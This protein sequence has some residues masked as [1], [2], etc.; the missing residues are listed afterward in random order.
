MIT[1]STCA[2]APPKPVRSRRFHAAAGLKSALQTDGAGGAIPKG[3]V[4]CQGSSC[5]RYLRK[6]EAPTGHL[7]Y[8]RG[9]RNLD[10][11]DV[12]E[13]GGDRFHDFP[14]QLPP[15][16]HHGEEATEYRFL[17][18]AASLFEE[19]L[20]L[21][22]AIDRQW[23]R[24]NRDEN[25]MHR[26]QYRLTLP[27]QPGG[28]VYNAEIVSLSHSFQHLSHAAGAVSLIRQHL[29]QFPCGPQARNGRAA[30]DFAQITATV[31]VRSAPAAHLPATR[32]RGRV[33]R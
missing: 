23:A 14:V 12:G 24:K 17:R 16:V 1:N 28:S 18:R 19:G 11:P 22:V 25:E 6:R 33:K 27:M 2:A 31:A 7:L 9:V 32:L 8:D 10:R 5:T 13:V 20:H 29:G 4:C 30:R 3:L 21:P 26:L 15:S